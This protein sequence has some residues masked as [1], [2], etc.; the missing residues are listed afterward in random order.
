MQVNLDY[1]VGKADDATQ[2]VHRLSLGSLQGA[3]VVDMLVG[4]PP[5]GNRIGEVGSALGVRDSVSTRRELT[6]DQLR[7]GLVRGLT[8]EVVAVIADLAALVN[9]AADAK[10]PVGERAAATLARRLGECSDRAHGYA[11]L[12]G[13]ERVATVRREIAGARDRV[14]PYLSEAAKRGAAL[15]FA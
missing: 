6:T 10:R 11:A 3:A 15:E 8:D 2:A 5:L 14:E 1:R 12:L 7:D 9:E 4:V 13:D